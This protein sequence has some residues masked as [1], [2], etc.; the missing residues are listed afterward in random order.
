MIEELDY[1]DQPK[2]E[3][4]ER[5]W[6][7]IRAEQSVL[8]CLLSFSQSA[9]EITSMLS[10]EDFSQRHRAIFE[11]VV[12][13]HHRGDSFDA[14]TVSQELEQEFEY[15]VDLASNATTKQWVAHCKVIKKYTTDREIYRASQAMSLIAHSDELPDEKLAR[16]AN[17]AENLDAEASRSNVKIY[18]MRD[19][20]KSTV[21]RIDRRFHG[22]VDPG[23]PTG[24]RDLDNPNNPKRVLISPGDLVILSGRPSMGKT[25]LAMNMVENSLVAGKNALFWSAEMP[26]RK[27]MD[28][29]ISSA[30]RIPLK[31]IQD[32]QL[33]EDEWVK[34]EAGARKLH[35]KNFKVI[36]DGGMYVQ[37]F[38]STA[39]KEH[40]K[41]KI[42]LIAV[43]YLQ[44]LQFQGADNPIL[45]AGETSKAL[46]R[47]AKNLDCVVIAVCQLNRGVE[48][49]SNKRPMISDL[50]ESGQIEQDADVILSVYR[51]EY[52][53]ENSKFKGVT[54]VICGKQRDGETGTNMLKTSLE[55]N[56]FDDLDLNYRPPEEDDSK[57]SYY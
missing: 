36:D 24:F 19:L 38:I 30:T 54:E 16:V 11:A 44:L 29:M 39:K 22:K 15:I 2:A 48:Q 14:L 28:R 1:P 45:N 5:D 50:R 51:D 46:K 8:G 13:Q 26:E 53:Y 42:D 55:Y 6:F 7:S 21:D 4:P 40:R 17:L 25:T 41:E 47:L 52:Y 32:G 43:D 34:L 3:S 12:S 31:R 9:D 20:L 56:R 10:P 49:R 33:T 27:I 23:L 18:E 57:G 37:E 35:G